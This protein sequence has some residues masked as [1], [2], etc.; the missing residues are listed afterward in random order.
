MSKIKRVQVRLR[1]IAP[2]LPA[3]TTL[4][5]RPSSPDTKTSGRSPPDISRNLELLK[6]L[7][8]HEIGQMIVLQSTDT[9]QA[10]ALLGRDT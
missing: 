10:V 1:A 9:K 8:V 7:E 5:D 4:G 2:Y 3:P 6:D